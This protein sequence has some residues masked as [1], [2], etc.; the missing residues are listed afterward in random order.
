MLLLADIN[1]MWYAV[2]LIIVI[3]LVYSATRHE[4]MNQILAHAG[5]LG[6]MIT[7]FMVVIMVAL[8]FLSSRL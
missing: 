4:K 3:S 6:A 8:Q 5:R 7:G 2:P 1:M